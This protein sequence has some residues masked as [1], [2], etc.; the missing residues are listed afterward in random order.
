MVDNYVFLDGSLDG[1]Y[2]FSLNLCLI[3][4]LIDSFL[5]N[6]MEVMRWLCGK[7]ANHLLKFNPQ[8]KTLS[9]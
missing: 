9:Y 5:E 6:R 2:L 1:H 4:M 7:F 3:F 8:Y